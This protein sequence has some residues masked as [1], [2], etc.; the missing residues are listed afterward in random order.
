MRFI[1]LD[2]PIGGI[3]LTSDGEA[4]TGLYFDGQ[5]HAPA[6]SGPETALPVFE[7]T[8]RWLA[9][10]FAGG[11]TGAP[12]KLA[13]SGTPFRQRVWA[14]LTEIPFGETVTYAALAKRLGTSARAVGAAVARNPVSIIVPCHRVIGRNGALT[15]YAGGLERKAYLLAHEGAQTRRNP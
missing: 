8:R 9:A 5:K 1:R 13:L 14:A 12:P 10:Y 11:P 7:T 4:L 2:S 6:L 15:G 3:T